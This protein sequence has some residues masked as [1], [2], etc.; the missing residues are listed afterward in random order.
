MYKELTCITIIN[1]NIKLLDV[2]YFSI[3]PIY[4]R[5]KINKPSTWILLILNISMWPLI[6][7]RFVVIKPQQN[8]WILFQINPLYKRTSYPLLQ[9]NPPHY[10]QKLSNHQYQYHWIEIQ[11]ISLYIN[12][13]EIHGAANYAVTIR[14]LTT[15]SL[16]LKRQ[17]QSWNKQRYIDII[18]AIAI[19][20]QEQIIKILLHERRISTYLTKQELLVRRGFPAVIK[21]WGF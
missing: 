6:F 9:N 1:F 14:S 12:I 19:S 18:A 5:N 11:C 8:K 17:A 3:L 10:L 15:D 7:N 20:P 16:A 13:Y 21:W 2:F 4:Y